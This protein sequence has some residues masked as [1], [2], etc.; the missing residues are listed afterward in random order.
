MSR[1]GSHADRR[2]RLRR[3]RRE[4]ERPL[5]VLA[6]ALRLPTVVRVRRPSPAF[7][8]AVLALFIA[9][10]GPAQAKRLLIDGSDIRKGTIRSTQI[11]DGTIAT[12]DISKSAQKALHVPADGSVTSAKL[13]A[14]AVTADKLAGGS[15]TAG[16]LATSAVGGLA[17]AD[18]SVAGPDIADGA[19]GTSKLVD[20][21]VTG[22]KIAD[23]SLTTNDIARFSGRFKVT[24]IGTIAPQ[25][26]WTGEPRGL[27][28]EAA[29]ADISQDALLVTPQS[30]YDS[31]LAFSYRLSGMTVDPGSISRFVLS[32][33][34]PTILPI[35]VPASGIAFN[36]VVLDIP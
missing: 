21:S 2:S 32:F 23:G 29:G 5:T 14:N 17:I 9:L 16:K 18:G 8:V 33:C 10:G 13:A 11:K 25:S 35:T 19:I 7:I 26:C 12:R 24:T 31:G 22:A 28:P 3:A 6:G 1:Y 15:V 36:Y 20:G 27:A 30:S 4:V 34:N